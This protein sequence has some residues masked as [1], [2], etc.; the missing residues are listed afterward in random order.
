MKESKKKSKTT[1]EYIQ[2]QVNALTNNPQCGTTHYNMAIGLIKEGRYD[3][4][5]EEISAAVESCPTLAEAYVAAGGICLHKGD[6][7]GCIHYNQRA[8]KVRPKFAPSYGNLGFAHLQRGEAEQA[9]PYLEKAVS[10]NPMFIQG[11]CSLS[12]AYFMQGLLDEAIEAANKALELDAAFA[13]AHNNIAL[14]YFEK[15]NFK[16]A[17]EHCDIAIKNGFDVEDKFLKDLEPHR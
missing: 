1:R 14:A 2:D 10:L 8:I 7:A 15:G 9:I 17:V 4:A 12:S 5:L 6:L 13:V 3:E 16:K 11:Y